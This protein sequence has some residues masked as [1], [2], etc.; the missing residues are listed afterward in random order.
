MCPS[1]KSVISSIQESICTEMLDE[2][3]SGGGGDGFWGGSWEMGGT[4]GLGYLCCG[5]VCS[6]G[7]APLPLSAAPVG[8]SHT[9][10]P[11]STIGLGF[12]LPHWP[13][14]TVDNFVFGLVSFISHLGAL[15]GSRT[16][17]TLL[18]LSQLLSLQGSGCRRRSLFFTWASRH[19]TTHLP[20]SERCS[21]LVQMM[22]R[23]KPSDQDFLLEHFP[24]S[25]PTIFFPSVLQLVRLSFILS[26]DA[27]VCPRGMQLVYLLPLDHLVHWS[28]RMI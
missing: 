24:I 23:K 18:A 26:P 5:L 22:Y 16:V 19:P 6:R 15:P 11:V 9:A 7:C 12:P 25:Q 8:V 17:T 10:I 21:S 20:T 3:C 4:E 1:A 13:M 27:P 14:L 2:S 28:R